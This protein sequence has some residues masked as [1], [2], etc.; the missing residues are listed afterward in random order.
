MG[1]DFSKLSNTELIERRNKLLGYLPY[2]GKKRKE[3]VDRFGYDCKN[4]SHMIR[5]L[6][7]GIEFLLSGELTVYRPDWEEL[8]EI[9][10]GKWTRS[11][12][13]A[14]ANRLF[15]EL[16]AAIVKSPLQEKPDYGA[17]NKLLVDILTE[18]NDPDSELY[19]D[20][21]SENIVGR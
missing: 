4:A 19:Q 7:M 5:I 6:R 16:G 14:E 1:K 18:Y 12:I 21:R 3:L 15:S 9:K 10:T 20:C 11:R 8:L 2:M 17:A 13:E